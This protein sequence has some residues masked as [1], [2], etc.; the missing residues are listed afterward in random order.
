[1]TYFVYSDH[2]G[3]NGKLLWQPVLQAFSKAILYSPLKTKGERPANV[4]TGY[5]C[6]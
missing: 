1:M 2:L 5:T 3:F 6:G 4:R